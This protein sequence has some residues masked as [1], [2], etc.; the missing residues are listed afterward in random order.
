MN[1]EVIAIG[2]ELL[3][4]QIVNTNAQFIAQKLADAGHNLYYQTVV[5]DNDKRLT[6]VFKQ[7]QQRADLIIVTGGLGPTQ[8]DITKETLARLLQRSLVKDTV[9]LAKIQQHF[10]GRQQAMTSNN[11][12]QA[13]V[14]EGATSLANKTGFAPGMLIVDKGITYVLMPGVPREM[15]P[16][17]EHVIAEYLT[18]NAT[19]PITSRVLRFYGIGE[20]RLADV[21]NTLITNQ[22]NPTLATYAGTYEVSLRISAVANPLKTAAVL[23]DEMEAEVQALVGNFFY[24]YGETG[25]EARVIEQLKQ[26]QLTLSAAESLTAG[27]FQ[28]TI[29]NH[30]GVSTI[31]KGGMVTYATSLKT[32]LLGVDAALIAREG[33]VSKG[34]AQAMAEQIRLR[35]QRISVLVS[36]V[37]LVQVAK[38]D[39]QLERFGLLL[40]QK[41]RRLLIY[42]TSMATASLI[43]S[44]L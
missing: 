36:P 20:S 30:A 27:L 16:M 22:T 3:L 8:D 33:V 34:C 38:M 37:S 44:G 43:V 39:T 24:G 41:Q 9:A 2:T 12:R 25:L 7:A 1:A 15:K 28:A 18:R 14:L 40:V 23:L 31:F 11:L 10:E 5:G 32:D 4:G 29:A 13:D 17:F 35:T 21:L 19:Q 6:A 42:I 26:K